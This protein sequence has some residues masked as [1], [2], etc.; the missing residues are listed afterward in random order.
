MW[1]PLNDKRSVDFTELHSV[2][3]V[4]LNVPF[5]T[6]WLQVNT[7]FCI[8]F[9]VIIL[10]LYIFITYFC[11]RHKVS[12]KVQSYG[13]CWVY[14]SY[15]VILRFKWL[16]FCFASSQENIKDVLNS[17]AQTE[18]THCDS[19]DSLMANPG[20]STLRHNEKEDN[21]HPKLITAS[22]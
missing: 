7:I 1:L 22:T 18:G 14:L 2:I 19:C 17:F 10:P 3:R 12:R 9:K 5:A 16:G 20:I 11:M 6:C 4:T 21:R 8:I 13:L 15:F